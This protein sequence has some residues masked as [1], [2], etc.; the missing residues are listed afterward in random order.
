MTLWLLECRVVCLTAGYFKSIVQSAIFCSDTMFTTAFVC[1]LIF[2]VFFFFCSFKDLKSNLLPQHVSGLSA[3]NDKLE[4]LLSFLPV[5][6][7]S[8]L[9]QN[10]QSNGDQLTKLLKAS[11]ESEKA[12]ESC[13]LDCRDFEET[14]QELSEEVQDVDRILATA[15]QPSSSLE[16]RRVQLKKLQVFVKERKFQ[17]CKGQ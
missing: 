1:A 8:A 4:K 14:V 3:V 5:D 17:L 2:W 11:E 15:Q 9:S 12:L 10:A 6:H 7:Q 13:L 16:E